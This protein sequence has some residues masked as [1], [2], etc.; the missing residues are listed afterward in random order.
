[1]HSMDINQF[2]GLPD[3]KKIQLKLTQSKFNA[4]P[5]QT[6]EQQINRHESILGICAHFAM[7]DYDLFIETISQATLDGLWPMAME[8]FVT[9]RLLDI[10]PYNELLE[11][12]HCYCCE[13]FQGHNT[14]TYRSLRYAPVIP[15]FGICKRAKSEGYS[16][17]L[18]RV[19]PDQRCVSWNPLKFYEDVIDYRIKRRTSQ[20]NANYVYDDYHKDLNTVDLWHYFQNRY[21]SKG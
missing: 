10:M 6:E 9:P 8:L 21:K 3:W 14:I 19:T 15:L 7:Q 11:F 16:K 2:L 17:S 12:G 13:H 5:I 18:T 1:M 4:Y 20:T